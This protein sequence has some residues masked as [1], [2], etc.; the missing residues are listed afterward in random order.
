[1]PRAPSALSLCK[2]E[3]ASVMV[4]TFSTIGCRAGYCLPS[5]PAHTASAA[6]SLSTAIVRLGFVGLCGV[7]VLAL[8]GEPVM[9]S[10]PFLG[11]CL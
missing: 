7:G 5:R 1:M 3:A 8:V 10:D 9:F 11:C 4:I 2:P 6:L